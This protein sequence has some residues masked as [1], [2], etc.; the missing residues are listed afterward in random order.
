MKKVIYTCIVGDYDDLTTPPFLEDWD[1]ICYT[2]QPLKSDIWEIRE[3]PTELKYLSP[4]KQQRYIK[5]HPHL[6]FPEYDFSLWIDANVTINKN[7]NKYIEQNCTE[8]GT[9]LFI[10]KHP[11]RN[12]IYREAITC[13]TMK[14]DSDE[15]INK[16]MDKYRNEGFPENMGLPQSCIIFR[17]H[18]EQSCIDLMNTWWN[19]IEQFSHRDQL[20]FNYALWKNPNTQVKYLDKSIFSNE[21]FYWSGVHKKR[22]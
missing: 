3:I 11:S 7:F 5:L 20:S 21:Y 14:K 6:L 2:D 22:K 1:Y 18:N 10:G 16:Q 8:E 13:K 4:I 19:E 15:I 9:V 17:Y 12:C